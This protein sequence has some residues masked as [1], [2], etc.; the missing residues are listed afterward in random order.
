[1][2][3]LSMDVRTGAG[4]LAPLRLTRRGRVVLFV[5]AVIVLG[6]LALWGGGAV[7]GGP[8]EPMEVRV[9]VV[10]AGETVWGYA[11]QL[12][13]P[14]ED[15]RDVVADLLALNGLDGATLQAGQRILLP[16]G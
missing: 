12:A 10:A 14:D 3:V 4:E 6:S 2:S 8:G 13:A 7:A 16:V 15:V 9:H 1:M 11:S 5:L